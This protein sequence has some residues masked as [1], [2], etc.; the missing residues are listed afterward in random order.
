M[1]L[2]ES[3]AISLTV[4]LVAYWFRYSLA[5][6]W[7]WAVPALVVSTAWIFA[8]QAHVILGLI[9][10]FHPTGS[11]NAIAVL[12]GVLMIVSGIFQLVRAPSGQLKLVMTPVRE[13]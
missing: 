9:V 8:R 1:I 5:P 12:L 6:S 3:I 13:A 2:S 10:A 11:L 4:L 7:R